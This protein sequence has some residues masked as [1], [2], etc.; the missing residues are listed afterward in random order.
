MKIAYIIT[1]IRPFHLWGKTISSIQLLDHHDYEILIISP[2]DFKYECANIPNTYYIKEPG[3]YGSVYA[4]NL[5]CKITDADWLAFLPDDFH[6]S[7]LDINAFKEFLDGSHMQ[8]KT[9]KMFS[10][11]TRSCHLVP[12]QEIYTTPVDKPYQVMHFPCVAKSTIDDKLGGVIF[13]HRFKHHYVD[14]W[15]GYY[16]SLHEQ[17][18]PYDYSVF[19]EGKECLLKLNNNSSNITNSSFTNNDYNILADLY[20][21]SLTNPNISYNA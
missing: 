2:Q 18:L 3:G 7:G 20:K 21:E 13:N 15:L 1:T 8:Q 9:F 16:A 10:F 19:N 17:Y 6:L 12:G 11:Y 14:H 4:N 5:G